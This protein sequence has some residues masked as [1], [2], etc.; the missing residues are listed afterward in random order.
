MQFQALIFL[1]S[2]LSKLVRRGALWGKRFYACSIK[3]KTLGEKK[4]A[5]AKK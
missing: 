5:K 3:N 1:Q 4:N 2:L